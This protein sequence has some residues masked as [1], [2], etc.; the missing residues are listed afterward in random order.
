MFIGCS[1]PVSPIVTTL[2]T[3][4]ERT[5]PP[6][7]YFSG[8]AHDFIEILCV[9]DGCAQ[10]TANGRILSLH[11]GEAILHPPLEFHRISN[12]QR[13]PLRVLTL[14]FAAREVEP[15]STVIS[16]YD[17]LYKRLQEL[18]EMVKDT[19]LFAEDGISVKEIRPGKQE[20]AK[21]VKNRLQSVLLEFLR[22]E[23]LSPAVNRSKKAQDYATI[24]QVFKDNLQTH[25]STEQIARLCRMSPSTLKKTVRDCS[26]MGV[27]TLLH[28]IKMQAACN[29]LREGLSIQEI[30]T[31]LGFD[32]PNYFCTFFKRKFGVPPTKWRLSHSPTR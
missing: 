4:F 32:N 30:S 17:D 25:L 11:A 15:C 18:Q 7:F 8:E 16:L 19:F 26:G 24:L 21:R 31:R 23:P 5:Y 20:Q 2:Y 9:L 12:P 1:L 6:D 22:T 10:V 29:F 27:I 13:T 3:Y 14:S 28:E